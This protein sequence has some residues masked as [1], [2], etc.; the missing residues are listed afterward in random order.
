MKKTPP[1]TIPEAVSTYMAVIGAKGGK[2]GKGAS[3]VRSAAH[4]RRMVAIRR[5]NKAEKD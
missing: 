1:N 3:K 5:R 2:N 4:Y